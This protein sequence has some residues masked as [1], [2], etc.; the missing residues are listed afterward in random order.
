MKKLTTIALLFTMIG[1]LFLLSACGEEEEDLS[2]KIEEKVIAYQTDLEDSASTLTS[3]DAIRDYLS[4]WAKSKGIACTTDSHGNVIMSVKASKEYKDADPTVI[5]CSYDAK[6]FENGIEPMAMALYIAKNNESTGK[7]DVIFT[8]ETG[9]DYAG[10]K[11]LDSQ[12]FKDNTNVFCL[13][14]GEKNMWST[15]TGARSSYTFSN[16]VAYTAPT[17]EKAYKI[18]I[19][20]LP[21]GIPDS[22]ISSYPNPIKELGDLLAYFKTNALIYELSD[23][24][25]GGSGNLYPKSASMT[26]V[27]DEDDIDKFESRMDTAIENFND[28]YLE[29]YPDVVYTYKEV[30]VPETVVTEE[31][32]NEFVS[33]LYT[34][35]DGVYYK[36]DDDNLI[37]ITSIGSI[38]SNDGSYTISAVGNSLSKTNLAEIDNTYKTICGLSG[39]K[40]KKTDEQPGFTSD[41]ES[42]FA[43]EVGAAFKEYA[44]ADI[45][46]KDC[47]PATNAS[48]VY[49]LN[50][51]A[52]II[53]VTVNEERMER[54][55]GTIITFMVN[56]EHTEQDD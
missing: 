42:E 21:G 34:L 5:V 29:D 14:S 19:S 51:K 20:G 36:D 12:Y 15:N 6:Q 49:E 17:G 7:L 10:I 50:K 43:K 11:S 22:K 39:V 30:K 46:F 47:V 4:N 52:N 18:K 31:Y 16:S 38:H 56:Q 44:D 45:E 28:D 3:T 2:S 23:I 35:L 48:Y 1:S 9:H 37:S 25:G 26:I 53:N 13:N 32:Q 40:Y 27:I 54:Y 8:N 55:T 33:L 41:M 24:T